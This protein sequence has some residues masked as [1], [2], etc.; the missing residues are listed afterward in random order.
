MHRLTTQWS[1]QRYD[2]LAS[3]GFKPWGYTMSNEKR[4]K[5]MQ[6]AKLEAKVVQR[7]VARGSEK[8]AKKYSK[9]KW[10]ILKKQSIDSHFMEPATAY[11]QALFCCSGLHNC[12]IAYEIRMIMASMNTSERERKRERERERE[13]ERKVRCKEQSWHMYRPHKLRMHSPLASW[14]STQWLA[15]INKHERKME[16]SQCEEWNAEVFVACAKKTDLQGGNERHR[17]PN[18]LDSRIL[19][20]VEQKFLLLWWA[21]EI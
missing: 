2:F 6:L 4:V 5:L 15:S 19:C 1:I 7:C 10:F 20:A 9:S 21:C 16:D 12:C 14:E 11:G 8:C 17:R 18:K 3:I 13:I